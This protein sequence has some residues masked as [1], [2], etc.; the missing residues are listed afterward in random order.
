[1]KT[2]LISLVIAGALIGGILG[3]CGASSDIPREPSQKH[4]IVVTSI[5]WKGQTCDLAYTSGGFAGTSPAM[6]LLGCYKP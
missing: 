2:W 5:Q 1:M 6:T 3:G 4:D